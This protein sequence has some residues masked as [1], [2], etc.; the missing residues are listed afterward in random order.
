MKKRSQIK[1]WLVAV[2]AAAVFAIAPMYYGL[3]AT[4]CIMQG[5]R[6]CK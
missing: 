6:R 4:G 3:F 2:L 1:G 5:E